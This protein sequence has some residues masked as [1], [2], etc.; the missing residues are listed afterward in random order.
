MTG[1]FVTATGTELGKSFICSQLLRFGN[2]QKIGFLPSKP[3]ISGWP[4]ASADIV[5]SDTGILLTASDLPINEENIAA[6]S[7]W[8]YTLPLAPDM[9]ATAEGRAIDTGA[10]IDFCHQRTRLAQKL[11]KM[12]LIEGVGGLMSPIN[13]AFTN[14]EWLCALKYPCLLVVGSYLG[15]LS[16]TLTALKVLTMQNVTVRAVVVNETLGSTV[17]FNDT[18]NYL[19]KYIAPIPVLSVTHQSKAPIVDSLLSL[20]RLIV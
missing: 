12:H 19:K 1:I 9:A 10:L 7:P 6:V 3:V 11:G 2:Q 8:R 17:G 18:V 14:L 13:G 15:S 20:Y 5:N 16:H 4:T